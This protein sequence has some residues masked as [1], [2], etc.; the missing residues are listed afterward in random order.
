[1]KTKSTT[2]SF[3]AIIIYVALCFFGS[4]SVFS[5]GA[6]INSTGAAAS[7][8]AILDVSSTSKGALFPRMTEAQKN[9]IS[10][11]STG[12]LIYQTDGTSGFYNYNGSNW[13]TVGGATQHFVGELYGGGVVFCAYGNHGLVVSLSD[14]STGYVW[15]NITNATVG[16]TTIDG[17]A[18]TTAIINQAGHTNSAASLCRAYTGGGYNDWYLPSVDEYSLMYDNRM[19]LYKALGY[20]ALPVTDYYWTSSEKTG[21][22]YVW[23]FNFANGTPDYQGKNN[24]SPIRAIRAF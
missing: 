21:S 5:Q 4:Y 9:A 8:S 19:I 24:P 12:L 17:N 11:P 20:S 10:A 23:C 18:N 2:L 22:P 6:A 1:M 16:T 13:V 7:S 14:I 3:K 15:S